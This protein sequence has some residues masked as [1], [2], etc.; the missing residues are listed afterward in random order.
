MPKGKRA[1]TATKGKRTNALPATTKGTPPPLFA[2]L[3]RVI[4]NPCSSGR[5]M[6]VVSADDAR[7]NFRQLALYVQ[8]NKAIL[9]YAGAEFMFNIT[10]NVVEV[11]KG[12]FGPGEQDFEE[13]R[14]MKVVEKGGI[15]SL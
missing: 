13:I 11:C 14:V 2:M 3:Q 9:D 7:R 10:D 12:R 4:A 15:I 6:L 5:Y 1:R 8:E